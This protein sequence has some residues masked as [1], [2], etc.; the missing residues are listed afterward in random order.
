MLRVADWSLNPLDSGAQRDVPPSRITSRKCRSHSSESR[1]RSLIWPPPSRKNRLRAR[2]SFGFRPDAAG[3]GK[4]VV[5][6]SSTR[7]QRARSA[8]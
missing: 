5:L 7:L 2:I 3:M 8:R 1:V 4:G 6:T